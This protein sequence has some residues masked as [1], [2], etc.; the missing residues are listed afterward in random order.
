MAKIATARPIGTAISEREAGHLEGAY[1]CIPDPT[2]GRAE[3][4]RGILDQEVQAQQAMDPIDEDVT[5]YRHEGNQRQDQ[6]Q[7][8]EGDEDVRLEA[9]TAACTKA[10]AE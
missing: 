4:G 7:H 3:V 1:E 6:R 5:E 2:T 10:V 9:A 8:G